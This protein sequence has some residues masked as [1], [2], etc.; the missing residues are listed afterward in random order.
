MI[1]V[2]N[3]GFDYFNCIKILGFE[4]PDIDYFIFD[5]GACDP[6]T[7]WIYEKIV[8]L[9]DLESNQYGNNTVGCDI[10]APLYLGMAGFGILDIFDDSPKLSFGKD[11]KVSYETGSD[12]PDVAYYMNKLN[13]RFIFYG[14]NNNNNNKNNRMF[15]NLMLTGR[16]IP[17]IV[18]YPAMVSDTSIVWILCNIS[19]IIYNYDTDND[20]NIRLN[21]I[22]YDY[23]KIN[24]IFYYYVKI[25][26]G[27]C[28]SPIWS[29]ILVNLFY[30]MFGVFECVFLG[31]LGEIT[32]CNMVLSVCHSYLHMS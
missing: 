17:G 11:K 2:I 19:D 27:Y 32:L 7:K 10:P 30:F 1:C 12:A 24:F 15:E 6:I 21:K 31:Y 23:N 16:S 25:Y 4:T 13:F 9:F 26:F 5:M 29:W 14:N 8:L 28:I 18:Y 3:G 22:L 20:N